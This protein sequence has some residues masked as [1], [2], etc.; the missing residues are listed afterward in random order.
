MLIR[1]LIYAGHEVTIWNEHPLGI[2][3]IEK[4]SVE[5]T[6]EGAHYKHALGTTKRSH[7]FGIVPQKLKAIRSIKQWVKDKC[8]REELDILWFNN[9]SFYDTWPVTR[10][11]QKLGVKTI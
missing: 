7:G 1:A 6:L 8:G 9:L 2:A 4:L 10:L 3:P 5:G 11:A